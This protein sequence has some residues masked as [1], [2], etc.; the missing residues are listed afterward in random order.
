MW[1]ANVEPSGSGRAAR[2]FVG[3][4]RAFV[5]AARAFV[6]TARAFVGAAMAFVFVKASKMQV[7]AIVKSAIMHQ[8]NMHDF[9]RALARKS[10]NA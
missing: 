10:A 9:S 6:G 5:G 3:A 2:A 8:S 1:G 7:C 4:A